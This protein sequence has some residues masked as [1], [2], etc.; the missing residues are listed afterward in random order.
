[1]Y[2]KVLIV[3]CMF[4]LVGCNKIDLESMSFDEI[5]DSGINTKIETSNVNAKGYRYF[6]P[7]EFTLIKDSDYVQ[8]L[9]S[10]GN[11][12]Y[13][14]ID[15]VSYYYKNI[16]KVEHEY[17]DYEYF[18]FEKDDKNGYLKIRKNND[19]FFVEICYNYAIIEVEVESSELRYAISRSIAILNSIKYNDLV[20]EKFIHNSDIDSSETVYKLPEPK[21][22]NETKNILEYIEEYDYEEEES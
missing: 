18:T 6:L 15:V 11:M 17:E 16:I 1:M 14:N 22:K 5:I 9:L 20:I 13:L 2:K 21:N 8:E 7:N 4:L 19:Y 10:H 12:Y 3:L